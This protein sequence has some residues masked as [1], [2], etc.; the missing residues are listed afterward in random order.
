MIKASTLSSSTLFALAL[1]GAAIGTGCSG[2]ARSDDST[3]TP[4]SNAAAHSF[5][6]AREVLALPGSG[7]IALSDSAVAVFGDSGFNH[8]HDGY[9]GRIYAADV[10]SGQ[11]PRQLDF[12][13]NSTLEYAR[14]S[15]NGQWVAWADRDRTDESIHGELTLVLRHRPSGREIRKTAPELGLWVPRLMVLADDAFYGV[16]AGQSGNDIFR[17]DL[18]EKTDE[19]IQIA[20]EAPCGSQLGIQS[21]EVIDNNLFVGCQNDYATREDGWSTKGSWSVVRTGFSFAEF[22]AQAASIQLTDP[23]EID[24][25]DGFISEFARHGANIAFAAWGLPDGTGERHDEATTTLKTVD[26]WGN[27]SLVANHL[28]FRMIPHLGRHSIAMDADAIFAV[29]A[30]HGVKPSAFYV[31]RV[32]KIDRTS[33]SLL[34]HETVRLA[35]SESDVSISSVFA[36]RAGLFVEGNVAGEHGSREALIAIG[37]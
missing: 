13:T 33:G 2:A 10:P 18:S 37:Q 25:G 26:A 30:H 16:T 6:E 29:S 20:A 23:T 34:E 12:R 7:E 1:A 27:V 4:T 3:D 31:Y 5:H 36:T 9:E 32:A 21:M 8:E 11:S 28:P 14:T 22:G 24:H 19:V 17:I 35:G 15:P